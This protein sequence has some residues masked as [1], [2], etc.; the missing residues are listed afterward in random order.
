MK[1]I[2]SSFLFLLFLLFLLVVAVSWWLWAIS[3]ACQTDCQAK[4]FVIEKGEGLSSIAENLG[5]EDLIRSSLAFRLL[6]AKEGLSR[7]IQAGDFRLNARMSSLEIAEGLTHGTLDRWVTFPEG[8]RREEIGEKLSQSDLPEFNLSEFLEGT[9]NLEGKLFPDTYLFP[10]EVTAQGAIEMMTKNFEKKTPQPSRETLIL[11]SI[12]EREAK[13]KED[14]PIIAGILLK[15][16]EADWPLQ[17][18]ATIQYA[19]GTRRC[20][21]QTQECEWW[22]KVLT[23]EDLAIKSPY[24]TYLNLGLPP[25][26]I[27]NPGLSVIEAV[28]N[29][30]QSDYWYYLSDSEGRMHYGKTEEEHFENIEKYL[31]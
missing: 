16:L 11:A 14:R 15:R 6:V 20:Q 17:T 8:W 26:P 18:D 23:R 1:K 25:A 5:K 21:G 24:N 30:T 4:I 28:L 10:K 3:P 9:R 12:I 13:Y 29:P 22:P 27:S 2:Q 19:I 7:K 31:R